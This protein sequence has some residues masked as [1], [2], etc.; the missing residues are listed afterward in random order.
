[1]PM[2]YENELYCGWQ[3]ESYKLIGGQNPTFEKES[4]ELTCCRGDWAAA[5]VAMRYTSP[6]VL[7]MEDRADF[8]PT[9]NVTLPESIN[10]NP[11]KTM[12]VKAVCED[13]DVTLY[14]TGNVLDDDDVYK[15]DPLYDSGSEYYRSWQP[16]QLFLEVKV[17]ENTKAG[18]YS[19]V[20]RVYLHTMFEDEV[21][22]RELPFTVKVEDIVMPAGSDRKFHLGIW[23]H[24]TNIARTHGVPLYSDRH[25]E[26]LESYIKSM[27]E[28]GNVVSSV[29]VADI[30]WAGQFCYRFQNPL[31]DLF[32][33]NI[34]K[35]TRSADGKFHYDYTALERYLQL[36]KKYD[37]IREVYLFGL[38]RN[39]EDPAANFG[40]ITEDYPDAIRLRYVEETDGTAKFMRKKDEI[41]DYIACLC[42]WLKENGWLEHCVV[43]AD[44]PPDMDAYNVSLE[45]LRE[46]A[47]ELKMQLDIS[48]SIINKRPELEFDSY[49][50]VISDIALSEEE[51]RGSSKKA[52]ARCKGKV[53]WSTCCWP[54]TPNS[55]IRSPLLEGR[56]HGLLAE[57]L[58]VDGF[59]RWAYTCWP[60]NPYKSAATMDWP[61]GDAFLVY[62]GKDGKPVL[63][64]RYFAMKRGVGDYELMQ[65]VKERC[66]GG[67][68]LVDECLDTVFRQ[69]DVTKWNF[70]GA[71]DT[72][73]S[74]DP[75]D[76]EKMKSCMMN[77]LL[78]ADGK[79]GE[80]N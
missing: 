4:I 74:F 76:Y 63:S 61:Y 46:A 3:H 19:G 34:V 53:S 33:Y 75:E 16:M 44:E 14:R 66:D 77:A 67:E 15:A 43:C 27:A 49:T 41:K 6:V 9:H 10:G 69:S 1:M 32:E 31:S 2:L 30:P 64:L 65:L 73:F 57:W 78:S 29:V 79:K 22:A 80:K 62:P 50:P 24:P 21:L 20:I 56:M 38:I 37:M 71:D 48:P 47:P 54:L 45:I 23:H 17:P 11:V 55:F 68:K 35:I 51:E 28:L 70:Y 13:L 8:T 25:F 42:K 12:R 58:K 36:C 18:T 52:M 5:S 72:M 39:W 60:Q 59:L 26:L 40:N 7:V